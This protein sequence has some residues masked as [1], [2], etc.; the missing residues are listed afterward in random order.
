MENIFFIAL[1]AVQITIYLTVKVTTFFNMLSSG[2]KPLNSPP[3]IT[4]P[5]LGTS[6]HAAQEAKH[7]AIARKRP[8]EYYS[9]S[10]TNVLG[11][12]RGWRRW[13]VENIG[14]VKEFDDSK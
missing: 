7:P 4:A 10:N 5:L 11:R 9:F 13:F 3:I 14:N 6:E 8:C 1:I 2:A 12:E